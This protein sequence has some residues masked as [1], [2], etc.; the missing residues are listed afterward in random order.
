MS[1]EGTSKCITKHTRSMTSCERRNELHCLQYEQN[2]DAINDCRRVLYHIITTRNT[3]QNYFPN[4]RKYKSLDYIMWRTFPINVYF[5]KA[6]PSPSISNVPQSTNNIVFIGESSHTLED[7]H[8][9]NL[10]TN[11]NLESSTNANPSLCHA[12]RVQ[13]LHAGVI[14]DI[15]HIVPYKVVGDSNML[16]NLV[17]NLQSID[18]GI[19]YIF[20]LPHYLANVLPPTKSLIIEIFHLDQ[21]RYFNS[22]IHC[23]YST[24]GTLIWIT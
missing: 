20:H 5:P 8:L 16:A 22:I 13:N 21:L 11:N 15:Q 2:K 3:V 18:V 14:D 12:R 9:Q 10:A 6:F 1:I 17:D 7:R 4:S 24:T 23:D 19:R